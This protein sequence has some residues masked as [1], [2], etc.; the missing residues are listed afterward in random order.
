[1]YRITVTYR[2]TTETLLKSED[3]KE[4]LKA[5][6]NTR[7]FYFEEDHS[8]GLEQKISGSWCKLQNGKGLELFKPSER[9][10]VNA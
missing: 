7:A 5:A 1:M 10:S 3:L 6:L 9:R 2:G 8:V 4:V